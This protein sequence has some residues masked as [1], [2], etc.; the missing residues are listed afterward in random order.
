MRSRPQALRVTGRVLTLTVQGG[1]LL[2]QIRVVG[3][4]KTGVFVHQVTEGSSA[5][6]SGVSP[7]AQ[8]LEVKYEQERQALRMVLEDST[9]EEAL[10]ALGQVQGPAWCTPASC[11]T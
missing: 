2:K 5:H 1:A 8:I 6:A 7:G 10:W 11:R 9:Q 4:N 3:G